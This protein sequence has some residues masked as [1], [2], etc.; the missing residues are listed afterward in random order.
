MTRALRATLAAVAWLGAAGCASVQR[1]YLAPE[2]EAPGAWTQSAGNVRVGDTEAIDAWWTVFNDSTLTGLIERVASDNLDLR[3]ALSRVREARAQVGIARANRMPLV[4]TGFTPSASHTPTE[5]RGGGPAAD[6]VQESFSLGADAS[7][8][9]DV[10][11]E[12]RAG[13]DLA[14]ASATAE[15][16]DLQDVLVSTAAET[17][18]QYIRLR[19][20][21]ERLDLTEQNIAL[22]ADT[23]D[24]AT[25]RFQA[26]LTTELDVYQARTN[27][28]STRAQ[29][30]SLELELAQTGNALAVLLGRQPDAIDALLVAPEPIPAAPLQI[31]LGVP[32]E[33][34]RQRPD[35]R[36]AE[37]RLAAQAAQ[38]NVARAQLYPSFNLV[39]SIG[40]ET[41]NLAR[42]LLPGAGLFR[43]SSSTTWSV[44]D[45]GQ[46]R[47]NL[48]VQSQREE[49]A[50]T[51]YE[52]AVLRA[53][54][55]V[56]DALVSYA[57]EQVRGERLT[58]A[59]DAA[60]QAADLAAQRYNTGLRD[61]RDVLDA[62]RS[63]VSLQDQL[64]ASRANVSTAVVQLY[65][66]LGGGWSVMPALPAP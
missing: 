5:A 30:A 46:L 57:Q 24:I 66:A 59:V 62:Q 11:G 49:Q 47:Q 28:E 8:E 14:T 53:V 26:G 3:S 12:R 17:A 33:A 18:S 60:Q 45:R 16:L 9:I 44:F 63:L 1:E 41:L 37:R 51:Q 6:F 25:F 20:L 10:F 39:G 23:L 35:I 22:Q 61:F 55:E 29:A 4:S 50:S 19:A 36:A 43:L 64:A 34:L 32:A 52:V 48:E 58:A 27:L 7:W 42:L 40:L 56:E 15:V 2:L 13:V 65:R 31:A 21:Q 38:T 54:Q